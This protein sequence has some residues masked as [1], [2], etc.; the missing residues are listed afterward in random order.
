MLYQWI[1]KSFDISPMALIALEGLAVALLV[2]AAAI[3]ALKIVIPI[4]KKHKANQPIHEALANH[5]VK[6]GTPTMGGIGFV[7]AFLFV[8]LLWIILEVAGV[9]GGL[10]K[11]RLVVFAY[12]I[13][14]GVFNSLVGVVDDIAKLKRK[15]NGGLSPKQK[16]VLQFVFAIAFV[17][18]MATS[19]N[20]TTSLI[21]PFTDHTLELGFFAYPLYVVAIV[22][23][24]NSTN[25]TDGLDG[26][27]SSVGITVASAVLFT[28][29]L[30]L[31]RYTGVLAGALIGALC[32]FLVFNHYPA[33]VFM[34]DTGSLFI[35]AV[36]IGC[37][38]AT[39]HVI[40]VMIMGMVF[41]LD[42]LS[43]FM[44]TTCYKLTKKRIFKCAP[45]HHHFEKIGWREPGIVCLF[46][47]VSLIFCVLGLT[48]V[49]LSL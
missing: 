37:G 43:S 36:L 1:N 4:L 35:G 26:L 20:L 33:K 24:V 16:L 34:G 22:G 40:A 49:I 48:G 23:F 7:I 17:A 15:Q 18:V 21:I 3:I 27:A 41:I 28:S 19:H 39:G 46:V 6:A 12:I 8:L 31:D 42:I 32:G 30:V 38:I 10:D 2:F 45:V 11:S 9:L 44:Q 29:C 25:I 5:S 47:I 13:L 14:L